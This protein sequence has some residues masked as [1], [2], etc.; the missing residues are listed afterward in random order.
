MGKKVLPS[1]GPV[2]FSVIT[3]TC[4]RPT[5]KRTIESMLAS[6]FSSEDELIVIGD[7]LQPEARKIADT[8]KEKM[9]ITYLETEPDHCVGH[10]QRNVAMKLATGSHLVS[11]D[12]D[13]EYIEDALGTMRRVASQ[14]YDKILIFRMNLKKRLDLIWKKKVVVECNVGTPLFVVPNIPS[15]LATWGRRYGGDY[16][17]IRSTVDKWPG[18]DAAIVW[19]ETV[20]VRVY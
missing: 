11:I 6:G 12:D 1:V 4:G 2:R 17:F 9:R 13:D 10:P 8:Y 18:Q 7:G 15:Q 3:P 16:E 20:I 14:S 5:L 19:D